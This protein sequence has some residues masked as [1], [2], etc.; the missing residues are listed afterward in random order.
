MNIF[1]P[2]SLPAEV[3]I[4]LLINNRWTPA[5]YIII[6]TISHI[7]QQPVALLALNFS[8]TNSLFLYVKIMKLL[9]S[10]IKLH[11]LTPQGFC[12]ILS[13]VFQQPVCRTVQFVAPTRNEDVGRQPKSFARHE[14]WIQQCLLGNYLSRY[15]TDSICYGFNL[16]FQNNDIKKQLTEQ[17]VQQETAQ[18]GLEQPK[19]QQILRLQKHRI[20]I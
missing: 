7:F 11:M 14:S 3:F 1:T 19:K 16:N 17:F 9:I 13:V 4:D 10:V 5:V 8:P 6:Q 12:Y 20:P 15:T 2:V 18:Q